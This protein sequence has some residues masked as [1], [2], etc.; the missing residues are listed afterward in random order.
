MAVWA[1]SMASRRS[2]RKEDLARAYLLEKAT[3]KC[4]RGLLTSMIGQREKVERFKTTLSEKV[5]TYSRFDEI[6]N[7]NLRIPYTPSTAARLAALWWMMTGGVISR[8]TPS[9]STSSPSLR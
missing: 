7:I 1:L 2:E 3:T 4:M 8:L 9:L 6:L 5:A